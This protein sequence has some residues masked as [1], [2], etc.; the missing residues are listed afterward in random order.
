LVVSIVDWIPQ[1]ITRRGGYGPLFRA[2]SL[3][4]LVLAGQ[5][6]LGN[7]ER[8]F[9]HKNYAVGS[10]AD[11]IR[12]DERGYFVA[13]ALDEIGRQ[14]APNDTLAVVP[15]GVMLNYL[16]RRVNPTPHINFMPPE[17]IMFGERSILAAFEAHPPDYV[18]VAHKQTEEYGLLYFGKD[19]GQKIH[20]WIME[21][22]TQ[23]KLWGEPPLQSPAFGILLLKRKSKE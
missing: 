7:F 10:G 22:Y 9:R 3:A 17:L 23:V 13:L 11:R 19:Y 5:G 6:F 16:S 12:A 4:L 21:N 18:A 8:W 1:M 20:A 14:L 2:G 15:E